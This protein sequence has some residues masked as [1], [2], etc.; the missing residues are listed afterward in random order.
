[1]GRLFLDAIEV[2]PSI[3]IQPINL[4]AGN[5]T[6]TSAL[7]TWGVPSPAPANGYA[8]YLSTVNTAPANDAT[9]SGFTSAGTNVRTLT[10]LSP[11]TTYYVWVRGNCGGIDFSQWS[12]MLSFT[13][14]NPPVYSYCTPAPSSTDGQG[15]VNV[16]VGSINNSTGQE[17][18]YYGNYSSQITNVAQG[19]TVNVAIT[20][21]TGYSY[22]TRI[23]IDWN[24]DSDFA[25]AG[26]MVYFGESTS[27]SPT[28]L[29]ASFVV[30]VGASLGQ[31]RMRIGGADF[32]NLS[33]TGAGQG[34]CY[35]GA[36]G[37]FEDYT[38][39]V[40][41]PPPALTLN[42]N[43]DTKCAGQNS[44]LV[45]I[46]SALSNYNTYSWS[47]STGISGSAAS[48]YTFNPNTTITYTL[49]GTQTSAPFS[50]NTVSFTY[51]A[52][53]LPTP[54]V[55]TPSSATTCLNGPAVQLSATG[56]IV[57]GITVL[58]ENFN[59]T[60]PGW[61]S[62]SA[63]TGGN[64]AAAN[65]TLRPS[66]YSPGG[67]TGIASV[68]S[69]D[70]TQ[71][72]ISN[73][74]AQGSGSTTNVTLTSP[75]FSLG[76]YTNASMS[77]YHY[78]RAWINGSARVEIFSGGAWNP[79]P[80][81]SWGTS[82]AG[83]QGA[84]TNF[85]HVVYNLNAYAGQ[86]NLQIRFHYTAQWGYI[87]A[88]DNFLITGSAA[89]SVTWSP[90]AGLYN[91]ASATIPYTG[92]G[93]N[94]VYALPSAT[95]TYSANASTPA[96]TVC[97]T[98]TD[99]VVTIT[100]VNAG[101]V[102]PASQSVCSAA[103]PLI[104]A[105]GTATVTQWQY[106]TNAAFTAGITNIP[107]SAS[108]TLSSAQIGSFTG[109]R[110]FRA[111]V[112]SGSCLGYSNIVSVD[113]N[114][115]TI[116][117]GSWSN[118]APTSTKKV[119]FSANYSS[120]SN[121][122]ACSVEV[123]AGN[124][125]INP[126]HI[127]H[128]QNEV[129]RSGGTLTFEND[130]SLVQ[131]NDASVN[132]GSIVYKRNTT[133][134]NRFDYTYWS[135]PLSPQ[136]LIGL[137]P[138]TLTDKFFSYNATA[139]TWTQVAPASLMTKGI[140]YIIR[141]GQDHHATNTSVFPAIFNGGS[142]NGVPNNGVV[143]VP[144]VRVGSN[145]LNFIGN[146]YPSA[147][148]ANLLVSH[149][150]N[151][152]LLGGTIYLWTHNTPITGGIYSNNDFALYNA[153]GSVGTAAINSGVNNSV[154]T[155]NIAAGQGFFIK[156]LASGTAIINNSM[157]VIGNNSNF[158]RS[159]SEQAFAEVEKHRIWLE[160]TSSSGLFKQILVGY[161]TDATNGIDRLYDGTTIET[162]STISLYSLV[163][164][165]QLAIQ[166]RA[167]PFTDSDLV[168]L[169]YKSSAAGILKIKLADFDGLFETTNVGIY[170][171]DKVL[172][173]IHDLRTAD[174]EF[175]TEQGTFNS[176]FVLRFTTEALSTDNFN[177]DNDE[178]IVYKENGTV[179]IASSVEDIS[180]VFV[181][182]IRGRRIAQ[183]NSVNHTKTVFMNLPE[184]QQVILVKVKT[185]TGKTTTRKIIF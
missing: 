182:D 144:I 35:T 54:I 103:S 48:G 148:D 181:Y 32:D 73:S 70:A 66:G 15:I 160:I 13:T 109:I 98:S 37:S 14:L 175:T 79:V 44:A 67:A 111:V 80:L 81:M 21:N 52:N 18:G 76:G 167:L 5:I 146:P 139:G 88:I 166:G 106:A 27:S 156:G 77:F 42:I 115:V 31:H 71:F 46:T 3:C 49:T 137:S 163:E 171:E 152:S 85:A 123:T 11:N 104:L 65:W 145:D 95:T 136:T 113:F 29:N 78:Y 149:A 12:S 157:R 185:A 164:N 83:T 38:V 82:P 63:S 41:V 110:Y 147:L 143:N 33:G 55:V 58:G 90:I 125:V 36:W 126:G 105:G 162:G 9:P 62:T 120:T 97:V 69:N 10:G 91:D 159:N 43:S 107:A 118:G 50:T 134:M 20:Y 172:G 102:S 96:P 119:V 150:S 59:G 151:S 47:P 6:G 140:G 100:N 2:I 57:S 116:W 53:A 122:D 92:T 138:L 165:N 26:E 84:P 93:T 173:I 174:Y 124:V 4:V 68:V 40:V 101:T 19:S 169:G 168:P 7:I 131:V 75:I 34:P 1:M 74:D 117:T 141:A 30:P 28:T 170:L 127:L 94:T 129:V 86:A 87:W 155:K 17:P 178:V 112:N 142:N 179:V 56:G 24:N 108:N 8:Y 132:S 16:T 64:V 23:W 128:V 99:V 135:S 177:F 184:T 61:V 161:T 39:N 154:P 158:F 45:S 25:D 130:A 89:S 60:A 114:A 153:L 51:N 22:Y 121:I 133:P 176:R 180:D 183:Q 72:Y